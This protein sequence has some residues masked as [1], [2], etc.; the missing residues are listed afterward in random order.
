M[1]HIARIELVTLW[2]ERSFLPSASRR[3]LCHQVKG[4]VIK[5]NFKV[6]I[7]VNQA[8]TPVRIVPLTSN[9]GNILVF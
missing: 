3:L 5:V 7:K 8:I 4:H 9:G 1:Q 6:V 2:P